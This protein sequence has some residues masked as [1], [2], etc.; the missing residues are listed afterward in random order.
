M[1]TPTNPRQV[2]MMENSKLLLIPARARKYVCITEQCP[3]KIHT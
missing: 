2:F 3:A 1:L